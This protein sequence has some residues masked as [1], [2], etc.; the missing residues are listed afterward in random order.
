MRPVKIGQRQ[1]GVVV[2]EQG[3]AAGAMVVTSGQFGVIPGGPVRFA[4]AA[5]QP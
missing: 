3:L 4:G 2:V 5:T 1:G